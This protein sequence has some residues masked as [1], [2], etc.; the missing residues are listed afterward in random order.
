MKRTCFVL[1]SYFFI[2]FIGC[3]ST[4]MPSS[5]SRFVQTQ[6][7][8][9]AE[10]HLRLFHPYKSDTVLVA[11]RTLPTVISLGRASYFVEIRT[12]AHQKLYGTLDVKNITKITELSHVKIEITAE[13]LRQVR[14]NQVSQI[15]VNDPTVQKLIIELNLGNKMPSDMHNMFESHG[16]K[17]L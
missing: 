7:D 5:T 16:I 3:S 17:T 13:I 10:A 15:V 1:L 4:I 12:K 6:W 9:P 2:V 11:D 14:D 8:Y